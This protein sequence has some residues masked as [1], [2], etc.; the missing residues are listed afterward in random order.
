M[1]A[2]RKIEAVWDQD[3]HDNSILVLEKEEGKLSLEEVKEFLAY[4]DRK[5][6]RLNS[7]H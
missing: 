2:P 6:T 5:S 7:S 1:K 3:T 4:S